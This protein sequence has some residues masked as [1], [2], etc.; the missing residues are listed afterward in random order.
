MQ[1]S[2]FC[3]GEMFSNNT[4][5]TSGTATMA[6]L[7]ITISILCFAFGCIIKDYNIINQCVLIITVGFAAL[8]VRKVTENKAI[9]SDLGADQPTDDTTN[10]PEAE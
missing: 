9:T 5:K 10:S 4:G 3:F 6:V 7:S 8:G 1:I 2:K